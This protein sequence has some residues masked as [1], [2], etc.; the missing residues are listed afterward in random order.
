MKRKKY[1]GKDPIKRLLY[2][3]REQI[4]KVLFIMNIWVW[5]SVFIGAIIFIFLM[6]KYYFI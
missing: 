6:V 1:Y 3:K 4:F 2:E 5:L